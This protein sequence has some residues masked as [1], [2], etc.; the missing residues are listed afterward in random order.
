MPDIAVAAVDRL[1]RGADRHIVFG[2]VVERVLARAD[3][4]FAPGHDR[5]HMR[6]ESH[7]RYLEA[8]LVVALAGA[9][10]R[11]RVGALLDGDLGL[12]PGDQRARDR[13]AEQVDPL[14]DRA[15]LEHWEQEVAY[16]LFAQIFY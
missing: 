14:V 12:A 8:H 4:P 11:Q 9:A 1:E 16:E 13:G 3:I 10:V 2:G 15:G 7:I 5:A 6:R